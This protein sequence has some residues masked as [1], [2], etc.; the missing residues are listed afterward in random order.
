MQDGGRRA[1]AHAIEITGS[2][3][4]VSARRQLRCI[5]AQQTPRSFQS[6][7]TSATC[8][9]SSV[10]TVSSIF[11]YQTRS[12]NFNSLFPLSLRAGFSPCLRTNLALGCSHGLRK[13]AHTSSV[14]SRPGSIAWIA[15]DRWHSSKD[16]STNRPHRWRERLK[17]S[18]TIRKGSETDREHAFGA[19]GKN[20]RIDPKSPPRADGPASS[21]GNKTLLDRLPHIPNIH[22]PTREE[23]LAA[24]TGFWSRQKVRF[25]WFSIRS[26]RPFNT[27]DISAFFSWFIVGHV[28]WIL[29]GTTT[30]FSLAIL[31]VNTVFAQGQSLRASGSDPCL[32]YCRDT[33]WMGR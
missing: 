25:K 6:R 23:L 17:S 12:S 2:L 1:C 33:C 32:Q 4:I 18:T 22:R 21:A 14:S 11:R 29:L 15:R 7:R 31:T 3:L 30:F 28:L 8:T 24:A 13:A 16:V 5:H 27:D 10:I 26:L 9:H 20:S 19:T